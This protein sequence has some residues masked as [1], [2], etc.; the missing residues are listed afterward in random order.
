MMYRETPLTLEQIGERIKAAIEASAFK[1][2]RAFAKHIGRSADAVYKMCQGKTLAQAEHLSNMARALGMTPND[3]LGFNSDEE[4]NALLE[5]FVGAFEEVAGLSEQ[6]SRELVQG[7]LI[8]IR[9][10]VVRS[11]DRASVLR[12]RG[13]AEARR[14][15]RSKLS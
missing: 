2:V 1:D 12:D 10:P 6:E 14:L 7:V 13:A 5:G 11:V 9:E 15:V 3:F 4:T 8:G